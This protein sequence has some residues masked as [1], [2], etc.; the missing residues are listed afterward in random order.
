MLPQ[1]LPGLH[2]NNGQEGAQEDPSHEEAEEQAAA[3]EE[4]EE[5]EV[6]EEG[7]EEEEEREEVAVLQRRPQAY[8][9]AREDGGHPAGLHTDAQQLSYDSLCEQLAA[10]ARCIKVSTTLPSMGS[11][12]FTVQGTSPASLLFW[13]WA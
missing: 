12:T 6:Q 3:Q 2:H 10:I 13:K 1:P 8:E 11:G 7:Q 5:E 9:A 4:V